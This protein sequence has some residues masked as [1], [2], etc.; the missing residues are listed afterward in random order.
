MTYEQEA[1]LKK[2]ESALKEFGAYDK[3][4]AYEQKAIEAAKGVES[5]EAVAKRA[6]EAAKA[7]GKDVISGAK[8][9]SNRILGKTKEEA[10]QTSIIY[11]KSRVEIFKKDKIGYIPT[12]NY[13]RN[14][15]YYET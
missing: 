13:Y 9:F 3:L 12:Y 4:K 10:I 7:G 6:V 11:T 5:T 14:G 15:K 1:F 2:Y 8:E